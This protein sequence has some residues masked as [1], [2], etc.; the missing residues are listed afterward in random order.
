[1]MKK[2]IFT[3]GLVAMT[4]AATSAASISLV[5]QGTETMILNQVDSKTFKKARSTS[6]GTSTVNVTVFGKTETVTQTLRPPTD[7]NADVTINVLDGSTLRIVDIKNAIDEN[8]KATIEKSLFGKVKSF[9]IHEQDYMRIYGPA[10]EKATK[11][12]LNLGKTTYASKILNAEDVFELTDL[13]CVRINDKELECKQ[14]FKLS[15]KL[16]F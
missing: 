11:Q 16:D 14:D 5:A 1:M 2:A 6:E 15:S 10:L 4:M 8:T 7:T 9:S 13:K 3:M 12:R